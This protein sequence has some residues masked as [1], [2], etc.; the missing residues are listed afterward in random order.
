MRCFDRVDN[1][2]MAIATR[3]FGNHS[4]VRLDLNVVLITAHGKEKRVPEA[5]RRL[6]PIFTDEVVRSVTAV[7]TRHRAVR[8]AEPGVE[9][10][11]HDV[12]VG[13]RRRI[14]GQIRPALGIRERICADADGDADHHPDQDSLNHAR[15]HLGFYSSASALVPD[16][17]ELLA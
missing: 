10:L 8:R 12:A 5:V 17:I 14:V 3:L 13:A 15:R 16:L 6:G 7:A 4:A 1:F 9:L 11:A 2:S